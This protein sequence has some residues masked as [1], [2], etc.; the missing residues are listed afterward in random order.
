MSEDYIETQNDMVT[1][2][3]ASMVIWGAGI[4]SADITGEAA[5]VLESARRGRIRLINICAHC[6]MKTC[7]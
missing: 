1:R 2:H 7:S 3:Q 4:E 5:K 6:S